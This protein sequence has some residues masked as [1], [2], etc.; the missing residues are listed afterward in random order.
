MA[1]RLCGTFL[2]PIKANIPRIGVP[3]GARIPCWKPAE[4]LA[5]APHPDPS[6]E[7]GG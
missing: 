3:G 4:R 1:D 5:A 7:Y 6:L 2:Q